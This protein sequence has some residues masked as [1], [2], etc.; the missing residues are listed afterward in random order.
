MRLSQ[1]EETWNLLV[2]GSIGSGKTTILRPLAKSAIKRG[3]RLIIFDFKRDVTQHLF[4]KPG[5]ILLA[6]WIGVSAVAHRRGCGEHPGGATVRKRPHP[7]IERCTYLGRG[8]RA[9]F[10]TSVQALMA[11]FPGDWCLGDLVASTSALLTDHEALRGHREH[12]PE[13]LSIV[14]TAPQTRT[15]FLMN[16]G[17]ALTPLADLAAAESLLP[18]DRVWSVK[19]WLRTPGPSRS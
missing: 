8:A 14:D 18:K 4:G 1:E 13:A 15:S 19:R 12:A 2:I 6:P 17:A 11:E 3:D 9:I 7:G 5:V 16:I 10:G